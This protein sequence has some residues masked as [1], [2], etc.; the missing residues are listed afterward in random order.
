MEKK[1][2]HWSKYISSGRLVCDCVQHGCCPPECSVSLMLMDGNH[3]KEDYESRLRSEGGSQHYFTLP[4]RS[5]GELNAISKASTAGIESLL[6]ASANPL[7]HLINHELG[8]KQSEHTAKKLKRESKNVADQPQS[9]SRMLQSQPV[10]A[11]CNRACCSH[12]EQMLF[13]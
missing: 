8:Q 5:A 11:G 9:P 10:C 12:V 6:S 4:L 1:D 7:L 2:C 13:M 3:W